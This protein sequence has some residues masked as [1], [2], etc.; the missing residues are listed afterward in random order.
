MLE[1]INNWQNEL[2]SFDESAP[3]DEDTFD[4]YI[5]D[6]K[7]KRKDY[8]DDFKIAGETIKEI[9]AKLIKEQNTARMDK[10]FQ[11]LDEIGEKNQRYYEE[12]GMSAY[13]VRNFPVAEEAYRR[14][15]KSCAEPELLIRYKNNLAYLIRRKEVRDLNLRSAKEVAILLRD[16]VEKND[17]FSLINMALFWA[18][19]CGTPDDWELADCLVNLINRDDALDAFFWWQNVAENDEA[20]GYLVHLMLLRHGKVPYSP[21]GDVSKLFDKVKEEY[22]HIPD[23]MR[24]IVTT[25]D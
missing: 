22:S 10:L 6:I 15:V 13:E 9:A 19:E 25:F 7:S 3:M 18:L 24:K 4:T 21:L 20:E 23:K 5:L 14:A 1:D 12:L 8:P 2:R 17:T 16:G 11:L